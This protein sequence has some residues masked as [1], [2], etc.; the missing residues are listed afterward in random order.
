MTAVTPND[1]RVRMLVT[2]LFTRSPQRDSSDPAKLSVIF[3]RRLAGGP[4][5]RR[6]RSRSPRSRGLKA[7]TR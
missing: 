3:T 6:R 4:H 1:T 2:M 7:L 5:P